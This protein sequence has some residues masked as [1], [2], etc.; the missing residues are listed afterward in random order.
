MRILLER[1]KDNKT[2]AVFSDLLVKD[3][4]FSIFWLFED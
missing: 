1:S 2:F 4:S 3:D